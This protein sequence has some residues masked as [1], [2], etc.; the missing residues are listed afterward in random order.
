MIYERSVLDMNNKAL[1]RYLLKDQLKTGSHIAVFHSTTTSHYALHWHNYIEL[2]LITDGS[3]NEI[4]NGQSLPL[5]RGSLSLL[6]L[7]DFHEIAPKPKLSI[8]K[9]I[10]DDSLI[11]KEMLS[12]ITSGQILFCQLDEKD[13]YALE[14]LMTLCMEEEHEA[15]PDQRYLK[16][17]LI[18]I[19]LRVLRMMPET[20]TAAQASERP[21]QAALLYMH[22]HFRESPQLKD[23]AK[24]A[25][26]TA[27]HFSATFHKE[28][29][30]TYSEYLNALK[31]NYAKELL[32]STSLKISDVCYEC[33]F[34]SHSN[35]LKL[36]REQTGFS[37]M[38]FKKNITNLF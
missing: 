13:T 9:M 11:S 32:L 8:I 12:E 10:I 14:R 6:R 38:Q 26:Y 28:L 29:G 37:P 25:H 15:F 34:T 31:I 4:L 20:K 27:S 18:C 1:H 5:K 2:E 33:G 19:L 17:L 3:G 30:M 16:H 22:M 24:V 35:F 36:F 7:T 21:I 23:V